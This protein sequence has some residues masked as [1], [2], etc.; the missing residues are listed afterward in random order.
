ML[1]AVGTIT[2]EWA[3][4]DAEVT[5]MCQ[6]FWSNQHPGQMMPRSFDKRSEYLKLYAVTLWRDEPSKQKGF[7]KYMQRVKTANGKRDDVCHGVPG[8]ITRRGRRYFGLRIVHPSQATRYPDMTVDQ[9]ERLAEEL[10]HLAAE[11]INVRVEFDK[12]RHGS[13]Q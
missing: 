4:I 11:T 3:F 6:S 13:S 5:Y 9:L 2:L 7:D 12:A 1:S 8:Q 10:G